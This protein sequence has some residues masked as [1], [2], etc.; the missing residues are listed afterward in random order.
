M[1]NSDPSYTVT[2]KPDTTSADI[3]RPVISKL[4]SAVRDDHQKGIERDPEDAAA[5]I[6]VNLREHRNPGQNH[7]ATSFNGDD[8]ELAREPTV[9]QIQRFDTL[10]PPIH[11]PTSQKKNRTSRSGARRAHKT[12]TQ[13]DRDRICSF[14][15]LHPHLTHQAI[16]EKLGR[17]RSTVSQVLCAEKKAQ[18]LRVKP[19]CEERFDINDAE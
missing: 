11:G 17:P 1:M 6:L 8:R 7:E 13:D 2:I 19:S 10:D 12:L 3:T 16:S 14:H 9:L 18:L 5:Y 4:S 15:I